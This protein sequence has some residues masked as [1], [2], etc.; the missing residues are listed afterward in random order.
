M[1]AST[2]R[3]NL[4]TKHAQ[5]DFLLITL[6]T[7]VS[8]LNGQTTIFYIVYLFWW[9]ELLRIIVDT[10]AYKQNPN[11]IR[12]NAEKNSLSGSVI[13]MIIYLVFIIVFFGIIANW[14]NKEITIVNINILAFHNLFFNLN[15]LFILAERIILH[16]LKQP[17][18]VYFGAFTPNMIVLHV[19]IILGAL[20][21]F[22][23]VRKYPD[24]FTP[25]NLWG[26]VL[27]ISPFLLL[28][29]IVG[30]KPPRRS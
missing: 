7:L 25:Y 23:V 29:G 8:I 5:W 11:A 19:S 14:K 17:V 24:T 6:F 4:L 1:Q 28:K 27:I 13:P 20:L 22:L 16:K 2:G 12:D 21:M 15:L 3:P 30:Y 9:N 26:S 18:Q 10:F